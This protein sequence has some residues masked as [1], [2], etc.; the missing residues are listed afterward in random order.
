MAPSELL[1]AESSAGACR[2]NASVA[3]ASERLCVAA[4]LSAMHLSLSALSDRRKQRRGLEVDPFGR[5]AELLVAFVVEQIVKVLMWWIGSV[6]IVL[7]NK[8][9]SRISPVTL[10]S[11][12][13]PL[14]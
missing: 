11:L 10:V 6:G 14:C 9:K 13:H 1:L 3:S 8:T 4:E 2:K 12:H 7:L 5:D